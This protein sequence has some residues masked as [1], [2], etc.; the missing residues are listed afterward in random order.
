M[1]AELMARLMVAGEGFALGFSLIMAIGAQNAFVLRMGMLRRHLL[2]LCLFCAVS[3]AL[4]ILAGV[5]GMGALIGNASSWRP[6]LFLLAGLWVG[7]YG[8]LRLRDAWR[9]TG[10]LHPAAGTDAADV[11]AAGSDGVFST[12]MIAAGLTWLNPHVYLDTLVLVGGVG[13]MLAPGLRWA[14]AGGAMLASLVFFF[15][16]GYGAA[17]LGRR[18]HSARTWRRIDLGIGVLMLW[19][20]GGLLLAALSE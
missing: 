2:V 8:L 9:G 15:G 3:D 18:L 10:E 5:L 19:L 20:A 7:G 13:A 6:W 16:L 12:L 4:L 1:T 11:E 14:F 17:W